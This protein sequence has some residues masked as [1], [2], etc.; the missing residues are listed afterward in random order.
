M[1]FF[2]FR[3]ASL[4]SPHLIASF[5]DFTNGSIRAKSNPAEISKSSLSDGASDFFDVLGAACEV[6]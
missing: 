3:G 4:G 1:Y 5:T 6:L 2:I